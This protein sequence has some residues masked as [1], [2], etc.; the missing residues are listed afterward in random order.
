[1]SDAERSVVT[2]QP[3]PAHTIPAV[4]MTP[5]AAAAAAA[6]GPTTPAAAAAAAAT[7]TSARP[8]N[9]YDTDSDPLRTFG[10]TPTQ[11]PRCSDRNGGEKLIFNFLVEDSRPFAKVPPG[12]LLRDEA[13]SSV[14]NESLD[15]CTCTSHCSSNCACNNSS[16]NASRSDPPEAYMI[17]IRNLPPTCTLDAIFLDFFQHRRREAAAG[18]SAALS[19]LLNPSSLPDHHRG[20]H[21]SSPPPAYYSISKVATDLLR[22]FPDIST[23]PEQV[24]VLYIMYVVMRWQIY[25]TRDNYDRLPDWIT[26]RPSQLFTPHPAWM[27]YVL[28]PRARD[29]MIAAHTLYPFENWFIPYTRTLSCNWPFSPTECILHRTDT[30][31]LVL[32]PVFEKHIRDLNNW[33]LGPAFAESFPALADAVRIRL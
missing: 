7:A 17:P 1:M 22:T 16:C 27:D 33:S 26:P 4:P 24:G 23:L 18:M 31:E 10:I 20:G 15:T 5:A 11:P 30:D 9:R 13:H 12:C 6:A 14:A 8:W 21:A 29:R 19:P 3:S 25:P 32:N 28:W 2:E